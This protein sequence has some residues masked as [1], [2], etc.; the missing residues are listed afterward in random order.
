MLPTFLSTLAIGYVCSHIEADNLDAVRC[1]SAH[2]AAL[3]P[4]VL[5][6]HLGNETEMVVLGS[7]SVIYS[8]CKEWPSFAGSN[9]RVRC[10]GRAATMTGR[11]LNSRA[12][13][14]TKMRK[15]ACLCS[16]PVSLSRYDLT[17]ATNT[18]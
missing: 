14:S 10:I 2:T 13:V 9:V 15:D 5:R 1:L 8:K 4:S 7:R 12:M 11:C 18:E 3:P 17:A 6:D 16:C